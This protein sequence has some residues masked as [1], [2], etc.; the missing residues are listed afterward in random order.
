MLNWLK[1][2]FQEPTPDTNNEQILS[3]EGEI[4]NLRLE[5]AERD[6]KIATLKQELERTRTNESTRISATL[7][8]ELEQLLGDIASPISQLL[9]QAH[10]LEIEGKPVQAKDILAVA[11]RLIRTLEDKGLT[12]TGKIGETVSFDPNYHQPLSSNIDLS[13]GTS[14]VVK[15]VGV[16]YQDKVLKKASVE[17]LE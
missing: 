6:Q 4:Q 9:T 13:T 5:L 17:P 3:L 16:S 12:I 2:L 8:T 11:K 7:Q 10:L 1:K 14:V 15:I